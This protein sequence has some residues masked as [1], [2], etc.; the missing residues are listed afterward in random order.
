MILQLLADPDER[1]R[2]GAIG[3]RRIVEELSWEFEA[4]KYIRAHT[5]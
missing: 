5:I 2:R 1:R 4:P 3:R